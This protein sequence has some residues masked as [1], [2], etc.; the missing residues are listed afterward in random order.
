MTNKQNQ[1]VAVI[2]N[3]QTLNMN[4]KMKNLHVLSVFLLNIYQMFIFM[5]HTGQAAIITVFQSRFKIIH[6]YPTYSR[7]GK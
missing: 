3:N 6:T 7:E 1:A 4:D 2:M 5:F